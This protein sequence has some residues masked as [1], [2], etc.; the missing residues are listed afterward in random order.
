M[1]YIEEPLEKAHARG[2]ESMPPQKFSENWV[3]SGAFC[4]SFKTDIW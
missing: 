1:L 4:G 2:S 3:L